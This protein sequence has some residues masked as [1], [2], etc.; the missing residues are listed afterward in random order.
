MFPAALNIKQEKLFLTA[1]GKSTKNS[2]FWIKNS[3]GSHLFPEAFPGSS[4]LYSHPE[5]VPKTPLDRSPPQFAQ[6]GEQHNGLYLFCK[7]L[8][9]PCQ[10]NFIYFPGMKGLFHL[11]HKFLCEKG[12]ILQLLRRI[13][14]SGI[15]HE[16]PKILK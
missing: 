7:E 5:Q 4:P 9:A 12:Q 3:A 14:R 13:F 1:D 8:Q 10:Q 6:F 15:T 2:G 16:P 11:N